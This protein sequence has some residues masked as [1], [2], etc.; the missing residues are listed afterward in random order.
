MVKVAVSESWMNC[1]RYVHRYAKV[2]A[3]RYAPKEGT[4]TPFC[5]WK[6]IDGLQDVLRPH[7][8]AKAEKAG[9]ITI[10][11]WMG[12]VATGDETA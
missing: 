6:R 7:E 4:E 10:E 12:K 2:Q 3:S 8:A 11:E 1:P 5:E 9:A